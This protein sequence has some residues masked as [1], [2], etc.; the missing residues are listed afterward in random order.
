MKRYFH[1]CPYCGAS[2]D[3]NETCDCQ[4]EKK[5]AAPKNGELNTQVKF[6]TFSEQSQE[7]EF[8]MLEN[9]NDVC[10]VC[11]YEIESGQDYIY[12]NGLHYHVDCLDDMRI[13]PMLKTLGFDVLTAEEGWL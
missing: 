10:S 13:K 6:T 2:L 8:G 1:Q 3:P 9:R 4:E 11:G 7:G 5:N 12:V